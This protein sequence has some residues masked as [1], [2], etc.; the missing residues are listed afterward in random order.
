MIKSKGQV[1]GTM[2]VVSLASRQFTSEEIR[3]L[4][5]IGHQIGV[6]IENARLYKEA[7]SSAVQLASLFEIGQSLTSSLDVDRTLRLIVEQAAKLLEGDIC[8]LFLYDR[9]TDELLGQVRYGASDEG[10]RG[11]RVPL[12]HSQPAAEAK[13]TLKPVVMEDASQDHRIPGEALEELNIKS[14]VIVPLVAESQFLGVIFLDW[15]KAPRRFT[16]NEIKL[17]QSFA[18][19]AAIALEN[20]QLYANSEELAINKERNRVAREIRDDLT[21]RLASLLMRIDLYLELI[22]EEPEEAKRE[23]HEMGGAVQDSIQE[24]RRSVFALRPLALE[25]LGFRRALSTY[26]DDFVLVHEISVHL[27]LPEERVRLPA[28]ME[29]TLFR[30]VQ[31]ALNNVRWHA[32]ADTVWID[33]GLR[34]PDR[35]WLEIRDDGRGFEPGKR[36]SDIPGDDG[37]GLGL[38][39]MRERVE[40]M[41]GSFRMETGPTVARRSR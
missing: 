9:D 35:I 29:Y 20:A 11:A 17:A 37:R 13:A 3:L 24:A 1:L 19:Q 39:H 10:L 41:R 28:R 12:S 8:T 25:Q 31:E 4:S 21:Q 22:D 5:S 18:S 30:I 14:S 33:L 34:S 2:E 6:A 16:A 38:L 23:L 26:T 36:A 32:Q 27:S 40:A 15:T 7:Q